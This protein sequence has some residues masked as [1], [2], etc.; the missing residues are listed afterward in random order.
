MSTP[1]TET[2][3]AKVCKLEQ[4]LF[5][6]RRK[7]MPMWWKKIKKKYKARKGRGQLI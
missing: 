3:N 2:A 7:K 6:L 1:D 5:I 4:A